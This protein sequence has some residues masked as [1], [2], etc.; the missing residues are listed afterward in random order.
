MATAVFALLP[1]LVVLALSYPLAASLT[2]A[3]LVPTVLLAR[4]G[5]PR[6][7]ALVEGRRTSLPLPGL[8][9]R[10]ELGLADEDTSS[11]R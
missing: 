5:A 11:A 3:L 8:G 4:R 9:L 6:V 2:V 10:L 1:P 7:A